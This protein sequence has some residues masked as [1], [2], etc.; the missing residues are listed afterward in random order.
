MSSKIGGGASRVWMVALVAGA[1]LAMT[2]AASAQNK[3]QSW[4]SAFGGKFSDTELMKAM[5]GRLGGLYQNLQVVVSVCGCEGFSLEG[6]RLL[7]GDFSV[8]TSRKFTLCETYLF[9][10][11]EKENDKTGLK[12]RADPARYMHGWYAEYFR[13]IEGDATR[14]AQQLHDFAVANDFKGNMNGSR[15]EGNAAGKLATIGDGAMG[16]RAAMWHTFGHGLQ[17]KTVDGILKANGYNNDRIDWA[18][19]DQ[20][21]NELEGVP[22]DRDGDRDTM[23][24][25]TGVI[26]NMRTYLQGQEG[27]RKALFVLSAHGTY[28]ARKAEK[29]EDAQPSQPRQGKSYTP[30]SGM[31]L[32][33]EPDD[34]VFRRGFF[35]G[36]RTDDPALEALAG[37]HP[38]FLLSTIEEDYTGLVAVL[39]DGVD[40]GSFSM[41][42]LP[43]GGNYRFDLS[44]AAWAGLFD[45]GAL[46]DSMLSFTFAFGSGEFQVAT[47]W[48]QELFD[49]DNF[50]IQLVGPGVIETP[51]PAAVGLLALAGV[52]AS[53]RR[54]A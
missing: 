39:C 23:F 47:E 27:Q 28:G 35:E 51:S 46:A 40:I 37:D 31:N 14:T 48:D 16:R 18:Y 49:L 13:G 44:D 54:R 8:A 1:S 7:N 15:I 38:M 12:V 10:N 21:G 19:A 52:A 34:D 45:A 29:K 50:G 5:R 26:E 3:N 11:N 33:I 42:G 6:Q 4:I 24:G 20:G 53:R 25:P 32:E 2:Q 22:I 43:D 9:S 36:F 17:V 41:L 30:G